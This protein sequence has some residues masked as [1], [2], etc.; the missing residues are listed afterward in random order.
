MKNTAEDKIDFDKLTFFN[1]PLEC[2]RYLLFLGAETITQDKIKKYKI[3]NLTF[4]ID[5]EYM[6]VYLYD[7]LSY[8][9]ARELDKAG[10]ERTYGHYHLV[11]SLEM[12]TY[13]VALVTNQNN[14]KQFLNDNINKMKEKTLLE[15][16]KIFDNYS[17]N[18]TFF[19]Q[20]DNAVIPFL[21]D[22]FQVDEF[23][24]NCSFQTTGIYKK[25]GSFCIQFEWKKYDKPNKLYSFSLHPYGSNFTIMYGKPF[26][27]NHEQIY[28]F[29]RKGNEEILYFPPKGIS[30]NRIKLNITRN[31]IE[32]ND[33]ERLATVFDYD[34][35]KKLQSEYCERKSN[36]KTL[37]LN[38]K[39]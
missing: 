3:G 8:Q 15:C 22:D 37:K 26:D 24:K 1:S 34:Y 12:L 23:I 31:S 39:K 25:E 2:E 20:F 38:R 6:C 19:S 30:D 5:Q 27:K 4:G 36:S 21:Q 29:F 33:Q 13:I 28:H 32:I 17:P 9:V 14:P 16:K 11:T 35:F 18:N 7:E 10:F